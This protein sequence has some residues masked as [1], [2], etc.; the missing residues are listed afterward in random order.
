ME[1]GGFDLCSMV[2]GGFVGGFG[3]LFDV[4]LIDDGEMEILCLWFVIELVVEV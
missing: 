3:V 2:E 4:K 1:S